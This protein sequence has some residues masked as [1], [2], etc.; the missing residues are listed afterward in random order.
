MDLLVYRCPG[1]HE[2]PVISWSSQLVQSDAALAAALAAGWHRT[3]PEAYAAHAA[4]T[5]I[6]A[7]VDEDQT[8]DDEAPPTREE[9]IAKAAELGMAVD[10][11]WSD[12]TLATRILEAMK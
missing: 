3:L 11:R 5:R 8:Y 6:L 7:A 4:P 2:G 10:K 9:M 12:K 1:T